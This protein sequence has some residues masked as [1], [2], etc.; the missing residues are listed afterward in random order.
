MKKNV[1]AILLVLSASTS[2]T[3]AITLQEREYNTWYAKNAIL[4]GMTQTSAGK[5]VMVSFSQPGFSSANLVVSMVAAGECADGSQL[6]NVNG[7]DVPAA[8]TCQ[9]INGNKIEH[10]SVVDADKVNGMIAHLKSDFTLLLQGDIKV[11]A[12]NVKTPRYGVAPRF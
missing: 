9:Q 11:W 1:T 2:A 4:Y 10:F 8:Y 7:K 6:L 5:P 12:A 3:A